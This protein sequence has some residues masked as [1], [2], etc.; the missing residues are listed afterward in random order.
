MD[1][2]ERLVFSFVYPKTEVLGHLALL[3]RSMVKQNIM[4]EVYAETSCLP[5]E[6][7][8]PSHLTYFHYTSPPKS[9]TTTQ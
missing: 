9:T 7:T 8:L 3:L 2:K 4:V 1:K 6:G 5:H